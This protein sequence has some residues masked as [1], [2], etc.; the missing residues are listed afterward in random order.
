MCYADADADGIVPGLEPVVAYHSAREVVTV[1]V[2]SVGGLPV[3]MSLFERGLSFF[4]SVMGFLVFG[5]ST[6]VLF[7]LSSGLG[8]STLF[9]PRA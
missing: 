1:V 9:A 4:K 3:S 5:V 6:A 7:C 8:C 2:F